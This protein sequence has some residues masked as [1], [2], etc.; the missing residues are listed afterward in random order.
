M[1]PGKH[2]R[3]WIRP[4]LR[5]SLSVALAW[6]LLVDY[7]IASPLAPAPPSPSSATQKPALQERVAGIPSGS[8]VEVR[9][10]TK[11]KIR[12]RLTD[13]TSEGFTV[14]YAVQDRI[15]ERKFAYPDVKSVKQV[16]GESEQAPGSPAP[17]LQEQVVGI[18]SGTVVVVQLKNKEKIR[19]RMADVSSDGFSVKSAAKDKVGERKIAYQDVKSVKRVG[20]ESAGGKTVLY[21]LAG[22]GAFVVILI[23]V[24]VARGAPVGD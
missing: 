10:K 16:S 13:V 24:W 1:L 11:E 2:D 3:P 20:N 7:A 18:P 9:L 23:L 8:L 17:T 15:E 21:V 19:G 4:A 22:I 5:G 6:V 12:G 14:R